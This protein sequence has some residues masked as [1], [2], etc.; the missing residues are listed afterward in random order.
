MEENHPRGWGWRSLGISAAQVCSAVFMA[1]PGL[2]KIVVICRHKLLNARY[3]FIP[4][5]STGGRD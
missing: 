4:R 2:D 5:S 1:R 3:S